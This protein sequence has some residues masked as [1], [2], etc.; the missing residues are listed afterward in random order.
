VENIAAG[1]PIP[2]SEDPTELVSV[3]ARLVKKGFRYYAA[4]IR[5]ASMAEAGIR[6]G[7][8]ALIRY[9]DTPVDGAIQVVRY[10]GRSTLKRLREIEGGGWEMHYEDGSGTVAPL[11]SGDYETQGD[12]VAVL[13]GIAVP[14]GR[15]T[16][17]E[18]HEKPVENR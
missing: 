3:P 7:D 17:R 1:P 9:A 4:T 5:G 12:C 15:K 2:Q 16:G 10:Q 18:A 6:D 14:E 13:T 8:V 11:D